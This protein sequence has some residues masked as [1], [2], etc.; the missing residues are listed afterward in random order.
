MGTHKKSILPLLGKTS[1]NDKCDLLRSSLFPPTP[2]LTPGLLSL[3]PALKDLSKLE[4][5]ITS[6]KVSNIIQKT[7]DSSALGHD[8]I[9]YKYISR[10]HQLS[11]SPLSILYN[12]LLRYNIYRSA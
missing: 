12:A 10:L 4:Y 2:Q 5:T 3:K 6:Q 1:F 11:P 7:K 8:S 9:S